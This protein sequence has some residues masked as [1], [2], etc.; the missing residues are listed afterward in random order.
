M[1]ASNFAQTGFNLPNFACPAGFDTSG[2]S[3]AESHHRRHHQ[4]R[5]A[6]GPRAFSL[7]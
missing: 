4:A 6:N 2:K 7:A 1:S 3:L 5:A